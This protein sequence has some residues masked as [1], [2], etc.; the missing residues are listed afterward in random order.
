[1]EQCGFII[2]DS[3]SNGDLVLLCPVRGRDGLLFTD[4]GTCL[5][6]VPK[7][8]LKLA[9]FVPLLLSMAHNIGS[10]SKPK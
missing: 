10:F 2:L 4:S 8:G 3:H 5:G 1:M 9:S 7:N 6:S